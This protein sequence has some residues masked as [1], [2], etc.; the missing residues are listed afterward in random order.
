MNENLELNMFDQTLKCLLTSKFFKTPVTGPNGITYERSVI[1]QHY[2]HGTLPFTIPNSS[3]EDRTE[4]N[5]N[6]LFYPAK[7]I[8]QQVEIY[9]K[10]HPEKAT[11]QYIELKLITEKIIKDICNNII[12]SFDLLTEYTDFDLLTEYLPRKSVYE[13]FVFIE[14][15]LKNCKNNNIIIHCI[16]NSKIIKKTTILNK[17]STTCFDELYYIFGSNNFVIIK[18]VIDNFTI[19]YEDYYFPPKVPYINKSVAE[20]VCQK[21]NYE[22]ISYFFSINSNFFCLQDKVPCDK[23]YHPITCIMNNNLVSIDDKLNFV[24]LFVTSCKENPKIMDTFYR[25][26][27]VLINAIRIIRTTSFEILKYLYLDPE[28]QC[29]W[30]YV[31]DKKASIK[32]SIID[33]L[34]GYVPKGATSAQFE[35]FLVDVFDKLTTN[36]LHQLTTD[37]E[38]LSYVIMYCSDSLILKLLTKDNSDQ[39]KSG[40]SILASLIQYRPKLVASCLHLFNNLCLCNFNNIIPASLCIIRNIDNL[41]HDTTIKQFKQTSTYQI[42]KRTKMQYLTSGIIFKLINVISDAIYLNVPIVKKLCKLMNGCRFAGLFKDNLSFLSKILTPTSYTNR[43][44]IRKYLR[45]KACEAGI[46]F[47]TYKNKNGVTI[48]HYSLMFNY[49]DDDI[50]DYRNYLDYLI[51]NGHDILAK[52]NYNNDL[53]DLCTIFLEPTEST[54]ELVEYLNKTFFNN[55]E[56]F[57]FK[58]PDN[59]ISIISYFEGCAAKNMKYTNR[60]LI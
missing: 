42:F 25:V 14:F 10:L 50:D 47:T 11:E 27:S 22:I 7:I 21:C 31:S 49:S 24:K 46:N 54:K 43:S 48:L 23:C 45:I 3:E 19:T 8:E 26:Q 30:D 36:E 40:W 16:N 57:K 37:T 60:N 41:T 1:L 29:L 12:L 44:I 18:Y 6:K 13:K 20:I 34:D 55:R 52:D 2:I 51:L 56:V 9:L 15:L 58:T 4:T 38:I 17:S 53:L 32:Y 35:S 33:L 39:I 28:S 59:D 5:F